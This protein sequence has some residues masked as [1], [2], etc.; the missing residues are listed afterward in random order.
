MKTFIAVLLVFALAGCDSNKGP[1]GDST[2]PPEPKTETGTTKD[3]K[4]Q[5]TTSV[6][7]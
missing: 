7:E 4:E 1:T 6:P 3:G 2:P 5:T